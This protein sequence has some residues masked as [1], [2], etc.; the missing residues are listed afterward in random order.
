MAKSKSP[1]FKIP[2]LATRL[3]RVCDVHAT[4]NTISGALDAAEVFGAVLGALPHEELWIAAISG[5]CEIRCLVKVA[6][7]GAHGCGAAIVDMLRPVIASGCSAFVMAHNH[8][9]GD[10]TPSPEDTAMTRTVIQACE[11]LGLTMLD[12]IVVAHGG[13]CVSLADLGLCT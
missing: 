8:P 3:V 5:R 7:G 1:K 9:S 12:H 11:L 6:Q 4:R 10:P 2:V 13:Q